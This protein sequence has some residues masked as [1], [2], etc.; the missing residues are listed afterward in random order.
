[1]SEGTIAAAP[2]FPAAL[3]SSQRNPGRISLSTCCG[4]ERESEAYG[5]LKVGGRPLVFN[6]DAVPLEEGVVEG[7][8]GEE[9]RRPVARVHAAL[10]LPKGGPGH[11]CG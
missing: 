6:Q 1:M 5:G 9:G 7:P 10:A 2:A 3:L 4:R 8:R 11:A